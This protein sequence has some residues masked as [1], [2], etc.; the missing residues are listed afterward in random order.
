MTCPSISAVIPTHK[1]PALLKRSIESV[2]SQTLPATEI[3][4]VDDAICEDTRAVVESY[5]DSKIHY[6]E[7][8]LGNGAGYSRNLGAETA[9]SEFVAFLDDDDIWVPQKLEFQWAEL[10]KS[11]VD[12]VFSSMLLQYENS[13]LSYS[14]FPILPANPKEEILIENFIGGTI[15]AVINRE[16]FLALGGFDASFPAREEYDLWI[17]LLSS[18]YKIS[19]VEKPLSVA[20]IAP[21]G[22]VRIS[23]SISNYEMAIKMINKKHSSLV[24]Q[25]LSKDKQTIRTSKQFEFLAARGVAIGLRLIPFI[26]YLRSFTNLPK[27]KPLVLAFLSLLS[28]KLM[29]FIRSRFNSGIYARI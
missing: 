11:K 3:L 1:R 5:K 12:A 25:N 8:S 9:T 22:R 7:N 14:T 6:V 18:G 20:Y 13:R 4:V 16:V 19:I 17:R 28:P 26:Y 21:L 24:S 15:S 29:L 10:R 27:L 2:I 23:S